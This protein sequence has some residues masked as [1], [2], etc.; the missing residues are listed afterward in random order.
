MTATP[1]SRVTDYPLLLI[2]DIATICLVQGLPLLLLPVPAYAGYSAIYLGYAAVLAVKFA[3]ISDVWGR[4]AGHAPHKPAAARPRRPA[5][6][7]LRAF[8]SALTLLAAAGGLLV[9]AGTAALADDALL[10]AIVWWAV[11]AAVFR[12]G[13]AYR[14]VAAGRLRSAGLA[15]LAGVA[16][17]LPAACG[18]AA[19]GAYGV[20]GACLCWAL[21]ATVGCA[22]LRAVPR[23]TPRSVRAWFTDGRDQIGTLAVES[24]L[25]NVES[26]GT[27][28]LLGAISGP[29]ALALFRAGSSLTYPVR[30][31][32]DALRARI[33]GGAIGVDRRS[34]LLVAG[35]GTVAGL[36]VSAFLLTAATAG[37]APHSAFGLLTHHVPDVGAWVLLTTLSTF[38]QFSGRGTLPPRALV[39]RRLGHTVI[40]VA[41]TVTAGLGFGPAAVIWGAVAGRV[42]AIGLWLPR[43]RAR[44]LT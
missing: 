5:A 30:M 32:L 1:R 43:C 36:G 2:G 23:C 28:L 26:L 31:V 29:A 40:V 44:T 9:G 15:E 19:S 35:L 34:L 25:K 27:P 39:A 21:A 33:V 41:A 42:V 16:C 12:A 8:E 6:A 13:V 14:L 7:Q 4:T 20:T 11:A 37:L 18:L 22:A 10:G 38:V 17:A 24:A 3:L